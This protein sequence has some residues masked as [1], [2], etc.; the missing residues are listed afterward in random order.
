VGFDPATGDLGIAVQSKF[1]GVGTVVPWAKAK[2]GAIATQSYANIEYGPEG[3][4]LL[5]T[6]KTAKETLATLTG[7]DP[8][9]E[10]RQVGIVDAQ[11]RPASF[12]GTE[13]NGWA[14]HHVGQN[15]CAQGNLLTD[16]TVI[17][18]MVKAYEQAR[19]IEGSQLADWLMAALQAGQEAGGDKRG[20]QSAALLVVREAAG[21][22]Q[23]NDR[24]IDL[25]VEDHAE[26]IRE[27]SRLLD[28]HKRFYGRAHANKPV[29]P[30]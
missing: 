1:F 15:F 14:G 28:I 5:E 12:T 11:G 24:F 23:R 19:Q 22:G 30:R 10:R 13:C 8:Q 26:P 9:R 7:A 6:G 25:R 18:A 21:Y 17:P 3:L 4:A 27:L 16:E 2:I 20:Q 29:R